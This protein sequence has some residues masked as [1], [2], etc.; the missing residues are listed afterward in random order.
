MAEIEEPSLPVESKTPRRGGTSSSLRASHRE[1]LETMGR[2]EAHE[3]LPS[4]GTEVFQEERGAR[5]GVEH[6]EGECGKG[7][8]SRRQ[9]INYD[10]CQIECQDT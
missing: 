10:D 1:G 9:D 6:G 3:S 2:G 5:E 4:S 8:G 7:W